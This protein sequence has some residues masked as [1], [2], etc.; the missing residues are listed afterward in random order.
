MAKTRAQI[1]AAWRK[2]NPERHKELCH[3][4]YR[5]RHS[6]LR[7]YQDRWRSNRD[8]Y[9][10]SNTIERMN[11]AIGWAKYKAS[12]LRASAKKRGHEISIDFND[13]LSIVTPKCP[14][15]GIDLDYSLGGNKN[16][17]RPESPSVDR[18]D[19][20]KGYIKGNIVI[21]SSLVNRVKSSLS[22]QDLPVVISK[23]LDYYQNEKY[24]K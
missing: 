24:K 10:G 6:F 19:N 7:D 5:D 22:L 1:S 17:T 21:V 13:I 4:Y 8:G 14:V 18:I 3:K 16:K 23:I 12:S 2:N 11:T 20:S 15:L 9:Y